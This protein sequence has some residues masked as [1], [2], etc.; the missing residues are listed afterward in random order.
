MRGKSSREDG[1][2]AGDKCEI[3]IEGSEIFLI[4]FFNLGDFPVVRRDNC[5]GKLN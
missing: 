4:T 5:L 1:D 2:W 3:K